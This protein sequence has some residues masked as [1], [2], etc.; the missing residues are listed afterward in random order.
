MLQCCLKLS[1]SYTGFG[2]P[3]RCRSRSPTTCALPGA[4]P[5]VLQSNLKMTATCAG[6]EVVRERPSYELSLAAARAGPEAT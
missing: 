4:T 3:R 5:H 2:L 1:T 6:L